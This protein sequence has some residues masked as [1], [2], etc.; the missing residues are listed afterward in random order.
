MAPGSHEPLPDSASGGADDALVGLADS[1]AEGHDVDWA[2]ATSSGEAEAELIEQLRIIDA[3]ARMHRSHSTIEADA[4]PEIGGRQAPAARTDPVSPLKA[5]DR[6]QHL[7]IVE[8]VGGG[9]FG[10]VYRARDTHLDR[11]VALKLL[12]RRVQTEALATQILSEGRLLARVAHPNVITIYGAES[13]NDRVGLWMEFIKGFT[14]E[15]MLAQ[16]GQ[17]SPREAT[18]IGLDLCRAL[19]AVHATGLVHR[20]VKAAN[21][22]REQGGRIVLMDFGTGQDLNHTGP[23]GRMAGTPLYLAPEIFLGE[24]A[25]VRSDLYSLGVLLYRLTTGAYPVNGMTL[26]DLAQAHRTG[27][28]VRMRDVR[29][30]L[31]N[32]FVN[33]VER[34]LSPQPEHRFESAGAMDAALAGWLGI[35]QRELHE[36]IAQT[37]GEPIEIGHGK[38]TAKPAPAAE[39][40]SGKWFRPASLGLMASAVAVIGIVIAALVGVLRKPAPA[41]APAAAPAGIQAIAVLPLRN[42]GGGDY[43]ADGMTEALIA[44]LGKTGALDVISRTSVMRFKDSKQALP[45]IAKALNVDAVIEGSVLRDG[46]RVRITAQLIDARTDR[47]LWANSYDRDV[48][49]VLALQGDVAR[50]IAQE[51]HFALTNKEESRLSEGRKP[52]KE[53]ALDAY[54]QGRFYQNRRGAESL[55]RA[56]NYFEQAIKIEPRYAQAYAG[57]ADTYI[58]LGSV[59]FRVAAHRSDGQSEGRCPAG[60]GHRRLDQRGAHIARDAPLLVRLG[61]ERR[62]GGIQEGSQPQSQLS[63]G[64]PL[65]RDLPLGDGAAR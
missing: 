16:H 9:T 14:L 58:L 56:V 32:A 41:A 26:R 10:D 28:F 15:D 43:F 40:P 5:G 30:T 55:T 11:E 42:L 62:R 25:T 61:L 46:R 49:D 48:K 22:M 3:V 7:V 17:Y 63:V 13:V 65:V 54:L 57:L 27:R 44:D 2:S 50:A 29:P 45:E 51:V 18:F 21:V 6:W 20:D 60:A 52:V 23:E 37:P 34:A 39:I 35:G 31:P 19:A 12:R 47:H 59:G 38:A 53:E 1:V 4:P 64:A 8:R 36:P 33:I 24:S